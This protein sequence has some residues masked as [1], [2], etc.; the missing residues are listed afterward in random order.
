MKLTHEYLSDCGFECDVEMNFTVHYWK[1]DTFELIDLSEI[2]NEYE[3]NWE[4]IIFSTKDKS[5]GNV[6]LIA[7]TDELDK[8]KVLLDLFDIDSKK[9]FK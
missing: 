5:Y 8:I 7:H 9:Y 2:G 1:D 6:R 4:L 3:C